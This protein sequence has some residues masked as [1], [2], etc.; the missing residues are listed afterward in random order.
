M[1]DEQWQQRIASTVEHWCEMARES[2]REV[3]A[4]HARP[5]AVFK[6]QLSVDGNQWC[7][8]YGN[9]LQEGVAGFGDSPANAMW[10]FDRNW[11]AKLK[12]LNHHA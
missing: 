3:A 4:E 7:A 12:E 5:S 2:V 11:S 6:P 10:D 1:L 8:L 9:N